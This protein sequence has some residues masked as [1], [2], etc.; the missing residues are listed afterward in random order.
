MLFVFVVAVGFAVFGIGL[1]DRR[2]PWLRDFVL[3]HEE[4]GFHEFPGSW[5]LLTEYPEHNC[6]DFP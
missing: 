3:V 2:R 6:Q 1:E 5:V 4:I